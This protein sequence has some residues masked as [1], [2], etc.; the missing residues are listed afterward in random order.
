MF[1]SEKVKTA[2]VENLS[3]QILHIR[4]MKYIVSITSS[5]QISGVDL[6]MH[7]FIVYLYTYKNNCSNLTD[8]RF[9]IF[10]KRL[11]NI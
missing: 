7:V 2:H 11:I 10:F 9:L 4:Q 3:D 8:T 1:K 6:Y 5:V